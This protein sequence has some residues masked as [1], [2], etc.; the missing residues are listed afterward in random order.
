MKKLSQFLEVH[1][2]ETPGAIYLNLESGVL[3]LEGIS[4][5]KI[6]RFHTSSTKLCIREYRIIVLPVNILTGL[7]RRLLAGAARHTTVCLDM[8]T[9]TFNIIKIIL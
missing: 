5:A 4:T 6:V 3:T 1:I 7:L 9:C 8:S 2:S